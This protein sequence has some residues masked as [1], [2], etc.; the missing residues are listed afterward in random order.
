M[1][2][3]DTGDLL[4]ITQSECGR[5]EATNLFTVTT[6]FEMR[7]QLNED[8]NPARHIQFLLDRGYLKRVACKKVYIDCDNSVEVTKIG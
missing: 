1:N 5:Y 8:T 4:V 2:M 7:D 3:F 6:S